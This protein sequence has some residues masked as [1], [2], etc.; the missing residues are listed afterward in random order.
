[1]RRGRRCARALKRKLPKLAAIA[2]AGVR[3]RAR[4]DGCRPV[5]ELTHDR[6][7]NAANAATLRAHARGAANVRGIEDDRRTM[8][9]ATRAWS[10]AELGAFEG[11][12]ALMPRLSGGLLPVLG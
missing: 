6:R 5:A 3:V 10:D 4:E 12:Q 7:R 8:F 9:V 11:D 1:M 2:R